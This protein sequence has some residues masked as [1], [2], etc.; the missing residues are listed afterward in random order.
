MTGR[1]LEHEPLFASVICGLVRHPWLLRRVLPQGP[2]NGPWGILP[3]CFQLEYVC[4]WVYDLS[5]EFIPKQTHIT[6]ETCQDTQGRLKANLS[7][8]M[9][10]IGRLRSKLHNTWDIAHNKS[11]TE[12]IASWITYKHIK[13]Y[14]A[15]RWLS[16]QTSWSSLKDSLSNNLKLYTLNQY[17]IIDYIWDLCNHENYVSI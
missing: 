17:Q 7:N 4:I 11:F 1:L 9:D 5:H 10:V 2:L 13:T 12:F 14:E 16:R 15:H 6:L 3:R 8:I